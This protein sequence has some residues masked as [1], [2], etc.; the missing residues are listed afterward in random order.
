MGWLD[1][2]QFGYDQPRLAF[3]VID[4]LKSPTFWDSFKYV[5]P[6]AWGQSSWGPI[7]IFFFAPFVMISRNPV[8]LSTLIAI[9]NL[10]SV[11]AV[12]YIGS[13]FISPFVGIVSGLFLATHPWWVIFSRMIYEPT[14]IPTFVS[15]GILVIFLVVKYKQTKW[16]IFLF[17]IW[18]VLLQLYYHA[19]TFVGIGFIGVLTQI[20]KISVKYLFVGIFV[21]LILFLPYAN[22]PLAYPFLKS[23]KP[24]NTASVVETP[25]KRL[26]D[27][28]PRFLES[29]SGG[30]FVWDLGYGFN[31]FVNAKPKLI[32]ISYFVTFLTALMLLYNVYQI[33]NVGNRLLRTLLILWTLAPVLFLSL[34]NL[35]DIL[36]LPRYFLISLPSVSILWGL[37]IEDIYKR[38]QIVGIVFLSI[39]LFW[40][41]FIFNYYKFIETY[42]YPKGILS[43]YSDPAYV[44]LDKAMRV[45]FDDQL[46]MGYRN[47]VVSYDASNPKKFSFNA[48]TEY[49]WRYVFNK[50]TTISNDSEVGYYLL[51]YSVDTPNN[52]LRIYRSGP[53][54]LY[55]FVGTSL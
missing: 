43:H 39:P 14:P 5:I 37:T 50:N 23:D 2:I 38:N 29:V 51:D 54:S 27:I 1:T 17:P 30:D 33:K 35:P 44:F 24:T 7:Q 55:R 28:G 42:D 25:L 16:I 45:M 20:N 52:Y 8:V 22:T 3:A 13:K 32:T 48:T 40:M 11:L 53:Y 26:G 31:D 10:I 21:S 49:A 9:F 36:P 46:K 41:V 47:I 12:I 18:S 6:N 4:F 15:L 34:V 19:I